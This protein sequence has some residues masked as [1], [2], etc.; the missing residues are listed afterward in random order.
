MGLSVIIGL[1]LPEQAWAYVLPDLWS[2]ADAV[3]KLLPAWAR[4]GPLS[5]SFPLRR[6]LTQTVARD[7]RHRG[8]S[9]KIGVA[10]RFPDWTAVG[11]RSS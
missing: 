6:K 8:R 9:P 1:R 7:S 5:M 3:G 11:F 10:E 2:R 4:L